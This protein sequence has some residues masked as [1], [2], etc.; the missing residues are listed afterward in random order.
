MTDHLVS[1]DHATGIL[2]GTPASPF[3]TTA[4]EMPVGVHTDKLAVHNDGL[5]GIQRYRGNLLF[6]LALDGGTLST[7]TT[8][9][10][11]AA[12]RVDTAADEV[13]ALN[14]WDSTVETFST[15]STP[16]SAGTVGSG[17]D[18]GTTERL[19]ALTL[20]PDGGTMAVV[21]PEFGV[22]RVRTRAGEDV[23][24]LDVPDA[25]LGSGESSQ[26]TLQVA[27][28]PGG[29]GPFYLFDRDTA[30]LHR[31]DTEDDYAF[32]GTTDLSEALASQADAP[33]TDWVYF[34]SDGS[35]MYVGPVQLAPSSGSVTGDPVPAGQ[36]I[37]GRDLERDLYWTVSQEAGEGGFTVTIHTVHRA[38]NTTAE[39]ELVLDGTHPIA[40]VFAFDT[41]NRRFV[42]GYPA[43]G[44][45]EAYDY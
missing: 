6:R 45:I 13:V 38:D 10:W 31:Y 12:L 32:L 24:T 1:P 43:T 28:H 16:V 36:V 44:T 21:Y 4:T 35:R 7:T 3:T 5:F 39:A 26:G 18:P 40:P 27:F 23:A 2:W 33:P 15:D 34:D 41:E 37:R 42:I 9:R 20:S 14:A 25:M 11:P 30:Q 8:G 29:A 19:P 17:F 22:V